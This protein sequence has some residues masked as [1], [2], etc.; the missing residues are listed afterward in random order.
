MEVSGHVHAPRLYLREEGLGV[1]FDYF[2]W[3]TGDFDNFRLRSE[4]LLIPQ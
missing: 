4:K 2:F 1:N 3:R